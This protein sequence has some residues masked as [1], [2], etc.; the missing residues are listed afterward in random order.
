MAASTT[1]PDVLASAAS[2]ELQEIWSPLNQVRLERR[3]WTDIMMLQR[4]GGVG[5]PAS[6]IRSSESVARPGSEVLDRIRAREL[7]VRHDLKARLEIFCE[8]AGHEYH[9]LGLTS[10]DVVENVTQIRIRQSL[11]WLQHAYPRWLDFRSL[12]DRYPLRGIKGPVGT[13]QDLLDLLG[14]K[15]RCDELERVLAGFYGFSSVA[16]SAP[17]VM[18]RSI[19][20]EVI[21]TLALQATSLPANPLHAVLRGFLQM[22]AGISGDTWN[23]G[24]VASSVVRRVAIPGAVYTTDLI[25]RGVKL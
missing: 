3:W 5:I 2:D 4:R 21:S 9:H 12:L 17:Q 15:E 10:A 18:F 19:D 24:D 7:V 13:Q 23:E 20:L 6:A 1:V 11:V 22:A 8:D 16:N 25:C 14:S